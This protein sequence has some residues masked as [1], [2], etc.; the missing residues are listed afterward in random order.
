MLCELWVT[1]S[2]YYQGETYPGYSRVVRGS[3]D[4]NNP[5]P[6]ISLS[7]A[8]PNGNVYSYYNDG[9]GGNFDGSGWMSQPSYLLKNCKPNSPDPNQACDCDN[10]GCVPK[11]TYNTPGKY[12]SLAACQSACAKDSSCVGECIPTADIAA[13]QQAANKAQANCCK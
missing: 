9:L 6:S 1:G 3:W 8:N 7:Q 2:V 12:P 4:D 11:T 13:L 10:G 5:L